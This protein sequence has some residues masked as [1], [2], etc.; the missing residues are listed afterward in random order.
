MDFEI[1]LARD[2]G[3]KVG[4]RHGVWGVRIHM[5]IPFLQIVTSR[6]LHKSDWTLDKLREHG[7]KAVFIGIGMPQ[8][9]RI[10][11]FDGLATKNGFYTSKDFLP[12]V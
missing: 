5:S 3:V 6:R 11:I 7:F 8:P 4:N 12:L 1:Q 10:P 9:K 2:I